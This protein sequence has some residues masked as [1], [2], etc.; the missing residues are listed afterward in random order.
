MPAGM[1]LVGC[2][3]MAGAMLRRWLETGTLAAEAVFVVNRQDRDLPAGVR[4]G[5]AFPSDAAPPAFLLLGVKPQQL[6]AIPQLPTSL[7]LRQER[8]GSEMGD[9]PPLISI[10]AGV[11]T[12]TL[13]SQFPGY[14]IIRAMPNLPV[15]LGKGVVAL[16]GA[17]TQAIDALMAPLGLAEWIN[18]EALFDAVTALAGSGPGFVYRFIDALAAAGAALGLPADQS[19][20]L[21]L[22]TVE[23]AGLL[24]AQADDSPAI[25]ADR[26]ASPGGSTR[27][28]LKVLDHEDSL[29]RLLRDTLAAAA[30]RNAEMADA[31]R[32]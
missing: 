29:K 2:G 30:R 14:P 25:L 27:E 1:W 10:L 24:A 7:S 13:Q 15:A 8:G 21:A 26:V 11:D 16:H 18:D 31:A 20:R 22:A 19:Q 9:L 12:A 28:G 23:G 4:Q 3:N 6:D 5:R 32:R 17:R